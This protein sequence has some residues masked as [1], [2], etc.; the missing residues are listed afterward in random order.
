MSKTGYFSA[1]SGMDSAKL[2]TLNT[3]TV[4]ANGTAS[5]VTAGTNDTTFYTVLWSDSLANGSYRLVMYDGG[6]ALAGLAEVTVDDTTVT[7]TST[8]GSTSIT[9]LPISSTVE[10]RVVDGKIT[11]F[12][13]E[14][15]SVAVNCSVTLTGMTLHVVVEDYLGADVHVITSVSVSGMTATFT[16]GTPVTDAV[17]QYRYSIRNTS[18]NVVISKGVIVVK[19]AASED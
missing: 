15:L 13:G 11:A 16:L 14:T 10:S 2:F 3:D 12:I 4:V 7:V 1:P 19:E 8:S 18:G 9:V 6:V 5:S 17:N